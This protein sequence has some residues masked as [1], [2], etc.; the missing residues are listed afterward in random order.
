MKRAKITLSAMVALAIV[1]GTLAFKVAKFT[2]T[3]LYT[4]DTDGNCTIEETVLTSAIGG[5]TILAS[6]IQGSRCTIFHVVVKEG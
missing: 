5:T 1:G 2:T 3:T 6:R 4:Q